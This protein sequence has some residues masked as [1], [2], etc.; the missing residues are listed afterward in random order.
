MDEL[1]VKLDVLKDRIQLVLSLRK[2]GHVDKDFY[3]DAV[4]KLRE[5][6]MLMEMLLKRKESF[7]I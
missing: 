7:F 3:H 2:L 1:D 6:M 4:Y 5:D